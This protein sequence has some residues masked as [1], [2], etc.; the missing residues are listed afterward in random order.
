[1]AIEKIARLAGHASL[2]G[3]SDRADLPLTGSTQF[4]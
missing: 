3:R 2:R 4:R 1:V